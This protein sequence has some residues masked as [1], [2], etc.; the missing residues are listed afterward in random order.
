MQYGHKKR[1]F[2]F[3]MSIVFLG[4]IVILL[5]R[6]SKFI[7]INIHFM[8]SSLFKI[9]RRPACL[10]VFLGSFSMI[11]FIFW[12]FSNFSLTK[13][14][15][16]EAYAVSEVVLE[17][18]ISLLFALFVAATVYRIRFFSHF[19]KQHSGAGLVGGFL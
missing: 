13:G 16:G 7:G 18:L 2:P 11:A 4:I 9:F 12:H 19:S 3:L 1:G 6:N 17:V 14:N 5:R 8:F 10:F 15:L